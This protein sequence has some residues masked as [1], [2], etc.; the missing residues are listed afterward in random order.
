M[1]TREQI[2]SIAQRLIQQRGVNGFSYADIAKEVGVSKPS[3]HHHFSTK[4][5]LVSQLFEQY[6]GQ[7]IAYLEQHNAKP[8]LEKLRAYCA[9]YR[10]TLDAERVCMGGML[11]A[12]ALTLDEGIHP[13][14]K[15]FFEVQKRWLID[16]FKELADSGQGY[17]IGSPE[18][19]AC[20]F[21]AGLQGALV[22]SRAAQSA[23]YFDLTVEGLMS[24]F[25]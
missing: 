25:D 5:E 4:T 9:L 3:L 2:L 23:D 20:A 6:T 8:P 11:S 14:L 13:Q 12:E 16:L 7:L 24:R 15:R 17:K 10:L 1:D 19:Q 22:V 18:Q 21:I